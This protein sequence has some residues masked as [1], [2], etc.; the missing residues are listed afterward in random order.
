MTEQ[1]QTA[2]KTEQQ[3]EAGANGQVTAK[4]AK[5]PKVNRGPFATLEKAQA[6]KPEDDKRARLFRV[7]APDG[8]V[9]WAWTGGPNDAILVVAKKAGFAASEH[10]KR[11]GPTQ[12]AAMRCRPETPKTKRCAVARKATMRCRFATR[13]RRKEARGR[14]VE[15]RIPEPSTALPQSW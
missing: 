13:L 8:R 12:N 9:S 7:Q 1:K 14:R 6:D 11:Y 5:K 15:A 2:Q 3:A 10:G 4:K